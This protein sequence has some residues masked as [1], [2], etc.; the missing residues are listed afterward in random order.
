M[1]MKQGW[2]WVC[3]SPRGWEAFCFAL[4]F[5]LSFFSLKLSLPQFFFFFFV[6][7]KNCA[8]EDIAIAFPDAGP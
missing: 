5:A 1:G 8:G 7:Q 6:L 2:V 4:P 3:V